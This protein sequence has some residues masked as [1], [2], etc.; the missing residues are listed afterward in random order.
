[1]VLLSG[2]ASALLTLPHQGIELAE[3]AAAMKEL[4][5]AGVDIRALNCI[6]KHCE[7]LKGGR[8]AALMHPMPCDTYILC[9]VIGDELETVGSG[10]TL[11]DPTTFEDAARVFDWQLKFTRASKALLPFLRDGAAGKHEETPKPG[12]PV[13]VHSRAVLVGSNSGALRAAARAAEERGFAVITRPGVVGDAAH[14]GRRLA[15]EAV[16]LPAGSAVIAGG[17]TTVDLQG[18]GGRGGRNQEM[19]LAAAVEIDGREG[20]AVTTFATDGVDGPTDAAG[21]IVTGRTCGL[22][23][24]AGLDPAAALAGHDSYSFFDALERAG[25]PHLIRTGPT[26][27]NVNDIA[28]AL[29]Y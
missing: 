26:G 18:K 7:R 19:A 22:A 10:P 28:I 14:A 1:V 23:R 13:L 12:D 20:I 24:E 11:G 5:G 3:Y 29:R 25:H 8:L 27:T 16:G 2:G 21:A 4:M 6:R 9:D 17:E 15:G